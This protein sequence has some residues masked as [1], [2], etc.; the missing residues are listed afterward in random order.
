MRC[1]LLERERSALDLYL[2]DESLLAASIRSGLDPK[3]VKGILAGANGGLGARFEVLGRVSKKDRKLPGLMYWSW[4]PAFN[5]AAYEMLMEVGAASSDFLACGLTGREDVVHLHLPEGVENVINI[6]QSI[7]S[8]SVPIDPPL[9]YSAVHVHLNAGFESLS[10]IFRTRPPGSSQVTPD[11][12]FCGDAVD[13]WSR[14]RLTGASFKQ[15][16]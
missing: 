13:G 12:Y 14:K 1:Y 15:V 9:P 10:P 16:A 5:S 8:H 7:F 6:N 3:Y 11:V 4:V 2:P